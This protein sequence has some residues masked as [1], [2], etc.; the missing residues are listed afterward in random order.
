M[1]VLFILAGVIVLLALYAVGLYNGLI[2]GRNLADEAKSGV[3][4]QLKRRADLIP[5]LVAAVK[6]YMGHE[7]GVLE[8]VTGLRSKIA[9]APDDTTRFR[10][11]GELT[12][13]L[14]RLFAVAESYPQLRASENFA[15]LQQDLAGIE[16]EIQMAR[17]YYNGAARA[18]NNRVQTFPANLLS[19]AFGFSV[20]PY[21][22]LDDPA[23]RNAPRV[24]FDD[25]AGS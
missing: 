9:A 24:S 7:R 20:L 14:G 11:E 21:F 22:E 8:S 4:V 15:S 17:R 3:D 18:Q 6:G 19:G 1:T 10:L 13:A 25:G 2:R 23:D 16:T 5:N 12:Q